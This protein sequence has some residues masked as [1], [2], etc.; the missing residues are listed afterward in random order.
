MTFAKVKHQASPE[1]GFWFEVAWGLWDRI[2]IGDE[3]LCDTARGLARGRVE[4]IIS[5]FSEDE[6]VKQYGFYPSA[7][8]IG[9]YTDYLSPDVIRI[10]KYLS[11]SRPGVDKIKK[12]IVEFYSKGGF[13]TKIEVNL[14][15]TLKDGY[16]AYLV[17]KMFGVN[18]LQ[19]CLISVGEESVYKTVL[20]RRRSDND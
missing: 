11:D 12:R 9:V 1:R 10:P 20:E 14:N 17:A 15:L 2:H 7:D 19:N 8:I 3:V 18:E 5:G 13:K 4:T 6:F 16:T